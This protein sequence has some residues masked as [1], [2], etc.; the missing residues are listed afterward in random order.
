MG[1]L[2][3]NR[4]VHWSPHARRQLAAKAAVLVSITLG[5]SGG[6]LLASGG[7]PLPAVQHGASATPPAT[8][9]FQLVYQDNF[10]T[11]V[12]PGGFSDC[13]HNPSTPAAYCGGAGGLPVGGGQLVVV[14]SGMA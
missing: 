8:P 3:W 9:G 13:N 5:V 14:P 10:A 12:P 11:D 7:S 1:G 2:P 4:G 6:S